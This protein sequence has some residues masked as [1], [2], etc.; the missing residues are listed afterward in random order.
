MKYVFGA[1]LALLVI[2]AS[3]QEGGWKRPDIPGDLMVDVGFNV[4]SSMPGALEKRTWSSKSIGLY[5]TKR[6]VLTGKLSFNYGAGLGLEKMSLGDSSTLFSNRLSGSG[7]NQT[8]EPVLIFPL[9]DTL[10]YSKNKLATTYLDIPVEFRFHPMG[11]EDGE[12]LFIGVGGIVGLRL[13]SHTKQKYDYQG[14]TVRDKVS[15]KYNLNPFRYG[16]QIRAGF[17]G[18]HLF[19]KRYVSDVFKDPF[20]DGSNPVLTTVGINVTGF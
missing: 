12:G 5:Y 9:S 11:T 6:K 17:K 13:N 20:A 18:V 10:S 3:A 7:A 4:W 14:E 2:T 8:L 15:G 16:Y 19:Y 1:V